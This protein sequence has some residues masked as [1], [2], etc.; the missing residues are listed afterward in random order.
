[1]KNLLAGI[2][3]PGAFAVAGIVAVLLWT[4]VDPVNRLEARV[5]GLDRPKLGEGEP[6][7]KPLTGT[8]T[9]FK[10]TA[11][12]LPG[13]WPRFRGERFDGIAAPGE[14][15]PGTGRPPGPK[16]S[17]RSSWAKGTPAPRARRPRLRARLRS[18]RLGRRAALPLAGRRPRPL[19]VQLSRQREAEPRHVATVPAVTDK[20]VV[21]IGPKCDVSCLDPT[22][23][24]GIG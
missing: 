24:T 13:A 21:A 12:N 16:C 17:G 15:L 10:Q 19:A 23:G 2:L 6:A 7:A 9:T 4:G 8:L 3:V 11:A 14:P 5:P 22:T 1:M 20:Y 18:H